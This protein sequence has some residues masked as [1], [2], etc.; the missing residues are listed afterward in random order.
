MLF[1]CKGSKNVAF[2]GDFGAYRAASGAFV[3]AKN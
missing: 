1:S 2:E 3:V